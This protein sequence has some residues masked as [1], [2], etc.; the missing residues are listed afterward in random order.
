M[1]TAQ[2]PRKRATIAEVARQA[3][4]A[5]ATV[6]G[7][8][9]DRADCYASQATRRRV[10]QTADRLNYRPNPMA[11]AL[12]GKATATVGLIVPAFYVEA[13]ALM[14]AGFEQAARDTEHL[15]LI[16]CTQNKPELEDQNI[17]SLRDQCVDGIAIYPTETGEHTELRRL[18]DQGFPVVTFDGANLLDFETDGVSADVRAGGYLAAKHLLDQGRRRIA[19]A[20]TLPRCSVNDEKIA[21]MRAAMADAGAPAPLMMDLDGE[22]SS[23]LTLNASRCEAVRAFLSAHEGQFDAVAALGDVLGMAAM[24]HAMQQGLNIPRDIAVTG[25]GG[26]EMASQATI[27]I[28]TIMHEPT[29]IGRLA[30]ELLDQ[31]L[32]AAREAGDICHTMYPPKLI[33][34]ESSAH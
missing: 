30:F 22:S 28:T 4:V 2:R 27:P 25:Y 33:V 9:N 7:I 5:Q 21:G 20:N 18:I 14:F 15:T 26:A 11:R 10:K 1:T 24:R 29:E 32:T 34:R 23:P 6:S 31:R 19:I 17:R 13:T 16:A 12:A 8:L 3:G